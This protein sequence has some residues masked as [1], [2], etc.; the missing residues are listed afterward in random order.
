MKK[1]ILYYY[2]R[3]PDGRVREDSEEIDYSGD[4][5]SLLIPHASKFS[6]WLMVFRK[7]NA[8]TLTYP[9]TLGMHLIDFFNSS[10]RPGEPSREFI[11]TKEIDEDTEMKMENTMRFE[12]H[13]D[14]LFL[15]LEEPVPLTSDAEMPCL[16]RLIQDDSP[17]GRNNKN[18]FISCLH[19]LYVIDSFVSNKNVVI[20]NGLIVT[21]HSRFEII[22]THV[23]PVKEGS[24]EWALHHLMQGKM[25]C[26]KKFPSIIYC[27]HASKI[28]REVRCG[29][30]DYMSIDAWLNGA[31][32]NGWQIYTEPKPLLAEAKVGDLCQRRDGKYVQVDSI[33]YDRPC[34]IMCKSDIGGMDCFGWDGK[35]YNALA[36]EKDIIHTEPL[37]PEGTAEWAWQMLMLRIPVSHP[38][39]GEFQETYYTKE[40][41][42]RCMAK[43]GWQIYKEPKPESEKIIHDIPADMHLKYFYLCKFKV[44][45][46]VRYDIDTYLR[47]IEASGDER[48]LCKTLSGIIVYPYTSCLSKIKPSEVVVKIGCLSGTIKKSCDP[49]YFSMRHSSPDMDRNYSVIKFSALDKETRELVEGLLKAQEEE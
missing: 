10:L 33:S 14:M 24:A 5:A 34:P 49:A 26:H 18:S 48:T 15:M 38:A 25:V 39:E 41:F 7:I 30:V 44:G 40:G 23:K 19:Q 28:M 43:T 16:V 4:N 35:N 12:K 20:E 11:G 6:A 27:K 47:V 45:D 21:H 8:S 17:M 31:H 32:K 29:W 1:F 2:K 37:A 22:G 36:G 13:N 42:V 3:Y 46:W 9:E